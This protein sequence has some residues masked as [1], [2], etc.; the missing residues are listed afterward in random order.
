LFKWENDIFHPTYLNQPFVKTPNAKPD[1]SLNFEQGEVI[2]E[3]TRVLEWIKFIQLYGLVAGAFFAL[4]VPTMLVFKT[5][6]TTDAASELILGNLHL[7]SPYMIDILKISLPIASG[8][9]L[10]TV[11]LLMNYINVT[12]SQYVI[13]MSYSRDK[14]NIFLF[15]NWYLSKK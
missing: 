13:K 15:R 9:I 2:Y 7:V 3:N 8:A 11:Y 6:L 5:N 10:Y 14:V 12:T 1:P 4:F